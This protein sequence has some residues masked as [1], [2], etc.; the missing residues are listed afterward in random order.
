MSKRDMSEEDLE[1]EVMAD[2]MRHAIASHRA[3]IAA[4]DVLH[5]T[6][7]DEVD[8]LRRNPSMK[9]YVQDTKRRA[10]VVIGPRLKAK[11]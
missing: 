6:F 1:R 7:K 2:R 3:R 10:N 11:V 9:S 8:W 5:Y 4:Q